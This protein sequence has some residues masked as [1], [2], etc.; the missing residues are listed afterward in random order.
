MLISKDQKKAPKK[1][2]PELKECLITEYVETG[3]G[4]GIS[5]IPLHEKEKN[6]DGEVLIT[7]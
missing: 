6:I 3:E 7:E 2:K 4:E 5:I 1:A